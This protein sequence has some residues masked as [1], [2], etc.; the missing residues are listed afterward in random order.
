MQKPVR[1]EQ[2]LGSKTMCLRAIMSTLDENN[3]IFACAGALEQA[4]SCWNVSGKRSMVQEQHCF[5]LANVP[6]P[7]SNNRR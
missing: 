1:L 4:I 2:Q 5:K 7:I 6:V 3:C